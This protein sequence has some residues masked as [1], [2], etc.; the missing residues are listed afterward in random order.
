MVYLNDNSVNYVVATLQENSQL[1]LYSGISPFY[2]WNF[3]SPSTNVGFYFVSDNLSSDVDKFRYDSFN[4]TL[5]SSTYVNLTAGTIHMS[6]GTFWDYTVYEQIN[7]YNLDPAQTVG[8]V[9]QGKA[10]MSATSIDNS[11]FTYY[12]GGS[13]TR[14][15]YKS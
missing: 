9:E 15:F 3:T 7:Q 5:T 1:Y 12:T 2:L 6:P 8:I 13:T 14:V 11:H 4:I 10:L